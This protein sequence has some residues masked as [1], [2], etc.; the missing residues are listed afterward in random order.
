[1]HHDKFGNPVDFND[2]LFNE[3]THIPIAELPEQ[4][5]IDFVN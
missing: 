3:K 5:I 4:T 1:M 2:P